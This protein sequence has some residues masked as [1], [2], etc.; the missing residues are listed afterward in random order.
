MKESRTRSVFKGMTF[1]LLATII[2][3]A[4][5]YSVTGDVALAAGIGV[6]DVIVK[7]I[8]YYVHERVWCNIH[9]GLQT[10]EVPIGQ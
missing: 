10:I 7:F 2:T 1:R 9:W 6:I 8:I 5:L 4:I 3:V